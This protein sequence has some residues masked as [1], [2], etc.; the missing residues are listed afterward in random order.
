MI[1]VT[2]G[3]TNRGTL[4]FGHK[5]WKTQTLPCESRNICFLDNILDDTVLF[6]M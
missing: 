5:S 1:K 2:L 6:Y 3:L 4:V